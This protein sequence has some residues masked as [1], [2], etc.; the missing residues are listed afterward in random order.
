MRL[1]EYQGKELFDEFGIRVPRSHL[2]HT[3]QEA[4]EG[5]NKLGYPLVIKSQLTVGGRGKAGAIVKCKTQAEMELNFNELL[6]KQVKGEFPRGILLEEMADI[7][8]ELYLSLFLN[9][10]KRCYSLISSAEGGIEIENAGSK[11]M[12]D[13]PIDGLDPQQAEETAARL[14]LKGETVISFVD[15]T[16]KLSKMVTEK[17]AELAEINPV[18]VLQDGSLMAL[19]AKVIIDDNAMFR[20]S[21]L[22]KYEHVSDLEKQA[23]VSGF[24]LVELD[25]NIAI[26]GNGAGLVMSTLDM[27][28]DAGGKAG[29]FLDFGGRATTETIYE[30]LKVISKI[31]KVEAILVNLFGG[32]VRTNLVAQAVLDAYKNNLMNVPVFARISGADSEKAREM[33][34]GSRAKLYNTVEEAID[35][36]VSAVNNSRGGSR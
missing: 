3:I 28:S 13:V 9:R 15:F 11:V 35:F 29:A 24:S 21:E 19:D 31:K 23:E 5:G 1:L 26:I 36:A 7:K 27:V 18:A 6:H 8:K 32:I 16:T 2:A 33:L 30:A 34:Q 25:G 14:G 22:K 20:H 12:V 10:S 17:E 4:R